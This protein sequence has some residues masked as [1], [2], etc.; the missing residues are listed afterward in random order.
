[1]KE[2][3]DKILAILEAQDAKI[4]ALET[5]LKAYTD[6]TDTLIS[7]NCFSPA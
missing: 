3:L 7:G 4:K 5:E 2:V 6:G 1:M